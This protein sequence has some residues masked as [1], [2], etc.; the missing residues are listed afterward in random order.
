MY[1]KQQGEEIKY[2]QYWSTVD[3]V[4]WKQ[5]LANFSMDG[6]V[7]E[8]EL[9]FEPGGSAG[10]WCLEPTHSCILGNTQGSPSGQ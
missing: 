4:E 5:A 8:S 7:V 2:Y 3:G 1:S 6:A 9:R 10:E